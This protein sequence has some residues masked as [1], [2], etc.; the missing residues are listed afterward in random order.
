MNIKSLL[1]VAFLAISCM[2]FAPSKVE[3]GHRYHYNRSST[4]VSVG[5]AACRPAPAYCGERVIV[6]RPC[7]RVVERVY[8]PSYGYAR[9]VVYVEEPYYEEV[10]VVQQRPVCPMPFFGFS[11]NFISR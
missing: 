9:E 2:A 8:A 10:V 3:A 4:Q 5:L 11:W 6:R 7:P 1:T